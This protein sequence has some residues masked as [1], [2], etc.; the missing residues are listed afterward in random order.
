[1]DFNST[2]RVVQAAGDMIIPTPGGST[3]LRQLTEENVE[4]LTKTTGKAAP[5]VAGRKALKIFRTIDALGEEMRKNGLVVPQ[6]EP[7]RTQA[8]GETALVPYIA[9]I[10]YVPTVALGPVAATPPRPQQQQPGNMI[11]DT[12]IAWGLAV[13]RPYAHLFKLGFT[14]ITWIPNLVILALA[15]Y[16]VA[17]MVYVLQHPGIIITGLF[18]ALDCVPNYAAFATG[19]IADQLRIELQARLR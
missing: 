13:A 11:M 9:P 5:L 16:L 8:A 12:F 4:W 2:R 18:M 17:A 10:Q 6:R 3:P 15:F 19:A 1:M 7:V 14:I